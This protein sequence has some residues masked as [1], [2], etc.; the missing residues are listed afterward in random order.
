MIIS[1]S[2]DRRTATR[3]ARFPA[4]RRRAHRLSEWKEVMKRVCVF[5][6]SKPGAKAAYTR[7]AEQL[8]RALVDRG[9]ALVYGGANCGLMATI[10]DTVLAAGGEV[11]GVIPDAMVSREVA[12]HGLSDLRVVASMHE[13]KAL[14]TE[15]SDAFIAL[16]GGYGTLDELFEAAA[17]RQ[18]R[19]HHKPCG[20]LNVEG[21]FDPLLAY[22]DNA[23]TEGFLQPRHRT[24]ILDD[25]DAER[26][27]ETMSGG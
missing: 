22:L 25:V 15:L 27:L 1:S 12:H 8:G 23:V 4:K 21:F 18:L 19:I 20:V 7:A 9:L 3:K 13:R 5:C 10:A 11:I 17:W 6:G 16:P 26:L 14:M 24:L 2:Y